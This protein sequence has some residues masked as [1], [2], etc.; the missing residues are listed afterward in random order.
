M[1]YPL[2]FRT[3]FP[4]LQCATAMAFFCRG[5]TGQDSTHTYKMSRRSP[6]VLLSRPSTPRCSRAL[7]AWLSAPQPPGSAPSVAV[8]KVGAPACSHPQPQRSPGLRAR[9]IAGGGRNMRHV[10]MQHMHVHHPGPRAAQAVAAIHGGHCTGLLRPRSGCAAIA[11]GPSPSVPARAGPAREQQRRSQCE[12]MGPRRARGD[13]GP[14]GAPDAPPLIFLPGPL[15]RAAPSPCRATRLLL[16]SCPLLAVGGLHS[17][18]ERRAPLPAP[19]CAAVRATSR[20]AGEDAQAAAHKSTARRTFLPKV[21]TA[22]GILP[23]R[24]VLVRGPK[25]RWSTNPLV[26]RGS[27]PTNIYHIVFFPKKSRKTILGIE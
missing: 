20:E 15:R 4:R 14:R 27:L 22:S 10:G 26:V 24:C 6:R 19:F 9:A 12:G 5:A 18:D 13:G 23:M 16:P 21:C 2:M 11:P 3:P 8:A 7:Q 25:K 17:C 1:G